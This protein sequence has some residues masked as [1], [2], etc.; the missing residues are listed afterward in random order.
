MTLSDIINDNVIMLVTTLGENYS[1]LKHVKYL[2]NYNDMSIVS[3]N[4]NIHYHRY[5]FLKTVK[6][7]T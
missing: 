5:S 7:K 3:W 6:K 1:I 2:I 4:I